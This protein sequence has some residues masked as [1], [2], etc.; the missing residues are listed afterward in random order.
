MEKLDLITVSAAFFLV[1][2]L[3]HFYIT[4]SSESVNLTDLIP[5]LVIVG[6]SKLD[7]LYTDYSI[8]KIALIA[9]M[10][11]KAVLYLIGSRVQNNTILLFDVLVAIGIMILLVSKI[12]IPRVIINASLIMVATSIII[13]KLKIMS[14]TNS[15]HNKEVV[16]VG[17]LGYIGM[18]A[19]GIGNNHFNIFMGLAILVLY[20]LSELA[21][22]LKYYRNA[23]IN[24]D[25]RLNSLEQKFERTVEF[26]AKKRTAHMTD[27]VEYIREKSQ[28]DP[29]SKA[30]N[31]HGIVSEI[32]AAITDTNIKI[33]SIAILDIDFFKAINDSKGHIVGDECIKFL[34]YTFMSH[35][36]K[37][38]Y[39]GRYGGDEFILLM[40]HVN[41]PA[42]LEICERI[43]KEIATKSS[44]KFSIS[45]GIA[46]YPYDGRTFTELVEVADKG[47]YHSKEQGRN[48]V[49]YLGVVPILK[50]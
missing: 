47:L 38:D 35:N 48:R 14:T 39:F 13:I 49:T 34:S 37:T 8:F 20:Q 21:V 44:P 36:R 23:S 31:R 4:K 32:N 33:F 17:F 3:Y 5:F 2:F 10:I 24:T 15:K 43:K 28:K 26:E 11:Y 46:S 25:T 45:M 12:I 30:L 16:E 41:A 50:K 29:L 18:I 7:M 9:C 6:T 40:P 22:S 1:N 42:A 27:K 19:L